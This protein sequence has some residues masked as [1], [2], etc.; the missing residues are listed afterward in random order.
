MKKRY[1]IPLLIVLMLIAARIALPYWVT[2]RVNTILQ[3]IPGY[4][5]S[6]SD[7][8]LHLYRGAYVIDSLRIEKMEGDLPVPF[9]FIDRIDLSVQ[10]PALLDGAIVGEIEFLAP[11]INFVAGSHE[12]GGQTG[13][14]VDWTEPI[15]DLM[16]LQINRFA[17]RNGTVRYIDYAS[18][19]QVDISLDSLQMQILNLN[20][21]EDLEEPLPSHLDLKAVS[22]G[23]G[24]LNIKADAN[25]LKKVPD[26]DLALEFEQVNLPD[27]NEF[28]EAYASVDAERGAF[29]L[30]SEF[31]AKDGMLE[32]YLKPII[33]DL[34]IL[35]ISEDDENPLAL[36]WESIVGL[37]TE[38]FENQPTDQFATKVPLGG[39]LNDAEAGVFPTIWNVFRN[40]FVDSFDKET[41]DEITF[42]LEGEP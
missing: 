37:V 32:G 1:W 42:G 22:V 34:K 8:D 17:I 40:A 39:N 25:V 27:L 33:T 26:F 12:F 31:A 10:W 9:V 38:I 20:N 3:D 11:D 19:P 16:P 7:V 29:F 18:D 35:D 2:N 15:K 28:L 41:D 21:A 24:K 5:G 14:N 6:V 13:E 36:A 4:T 30:Y 23:N